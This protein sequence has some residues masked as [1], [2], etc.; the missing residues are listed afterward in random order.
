VSFPLHSTFPS[1]N[2]MAFITH[3]NETTRTNV[4]SR[5]R[6]VFARLQ[7]LNE[8]VILFDEIEEFCLD[9]ESPGLVSLE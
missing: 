7:S 5:I 8:C 4:A 9:R 6:Y 2:V 1:H 3:Y